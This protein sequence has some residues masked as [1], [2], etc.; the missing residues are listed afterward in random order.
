MK[1]IGANI[2]DIDWQILQMGL[3]T[4]FGSPQGVTYQY[5]GSLVG[6]DERV[7]LRLSLEN[8]LIIKAVGV[9]E[10]PTGIPF[11]PTISEEA[12]EAIEDVLE[13]AATKGRPSQN[14]K[15]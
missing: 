15:L 13:F 11:Q 12:I 7:T 8:E 9:V 2:R 10:T 5:P 1:I 4:S 14:M 6:T 3:T